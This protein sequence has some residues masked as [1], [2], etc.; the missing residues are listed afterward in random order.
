MN[1]TLKYIDEAGKLVWSELLTK[2]KLKGESDHMKYKVI[3]TKVVDDGEKKDVILD[4]MKYKI[5]GTKVV[6]GSQVI[7]VRKQ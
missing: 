7:I 4:H 6:D 2:E 1:R 5:I 3:G